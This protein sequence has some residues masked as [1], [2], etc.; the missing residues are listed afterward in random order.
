M[1]R[2]VGGAA[3]A[4]GAALALGLRG[5]AGAAVGLRV[6]EGAVVVAEL[7]QAPRRVRVGRFGVWLG[8]VLF[9]WTRDLGKINNE[10]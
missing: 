6:E 3:A 4:A 9:L 2:R 7:E 1:A 8:I 5:Q 10:K